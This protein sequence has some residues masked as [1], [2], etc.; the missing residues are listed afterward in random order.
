MIQSIRKFQIDTVSTAK[1]QCSR[2]FPPQN[3]SYVT[4]IVGL[5][6]EKERRLSYLPGKG[7][8]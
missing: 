4:N 5:Y 2:D 1:I 6:E 3:S 8:V 7:F